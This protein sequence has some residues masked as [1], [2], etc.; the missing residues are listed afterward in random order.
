MKDARCG[1]SIKNTSYAALHVLF[2]KKK[3]GRIEFCTVL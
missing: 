1:E 3:A 2:A